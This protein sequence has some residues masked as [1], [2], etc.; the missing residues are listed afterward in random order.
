M[1]GAP[2]LYA[3]PNVEITILNLDAEESRDENLIVRPGNACSTGLPDMSFD[4][5]HSNSVIE[6]VG[7]GAAMKAMAGE[8]SRLAPSYFVQTPNYWFP[9]EPHYKLPLVQYLPYSAQAVVIDK[10]G[11]NQTKFGP[12]LVDPRDLVKQTRLIGARQMRQLFPD[13]RLWRERLFGLTKSLVALRD[14]R[15]FHDDL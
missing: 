8:V 7:D 10:L 6:H 13:A 14:N 5:V 2:G 4:V 11:A 9:V 1:A 12:V 15:S 3:M